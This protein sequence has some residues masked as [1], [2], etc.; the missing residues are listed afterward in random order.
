ME[1]AAP[2]KPQSQAYPAGWGQWQKAGTGGCMAACALPFA[3]HG[4]NQKEDLSRTS[5]VL[6]CAAPTVA[7]PIRPLQNRK[8]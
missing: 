3:G 7:I 8:F 6:N 4:L 1:A 5:K 2:T